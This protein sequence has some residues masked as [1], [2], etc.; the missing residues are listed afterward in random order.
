MQIADND[1]YGNL[2][3]LQLEA[4]RAARLVMDSGIHSRG[5]SFQRTVRFNTDNVGVST[6]SSQGATSRYGVIP[7]QK[8]P[9]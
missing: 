1:V 8:T 3:R 2:G 9:A 7:G 4:L 5:W 6:W